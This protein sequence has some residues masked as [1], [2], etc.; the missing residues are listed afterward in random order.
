M[1][2]SVDKIIAVASGKG[3]VGKSTFASNVAFELVNRGFKV[4]VLD[5]D[6]HGPSQPTLLGSHE[7][8]KIDKES[9]YLTIKNLILASNNI[10]WQ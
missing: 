3:G 6:M 10:I 4:G 5:A 7:K 1:A 8:P 9:K 2:K